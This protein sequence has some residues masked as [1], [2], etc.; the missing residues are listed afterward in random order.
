MVIFSV[1]HAFS[2]HG[3]NRGL[4]GRYPSTATRGPAKRKLVYK[5]YQYKCSADHYIEFPTSMMS[6]NLTKVV[7]SDKF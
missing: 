3:E 1:G 4:K 6:I 2:S 7:V 5:T